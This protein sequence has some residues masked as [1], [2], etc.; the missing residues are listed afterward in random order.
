MKKFLA[1][2]LTLLMVLSLGTVAL[3]GHVYED[4]VTGG[5]CELD[6]ARGEHLQPGESYVFGPDGS[7]I[8]LTEVDGDVGNTTASDAVNVDGVEDAI[9]SL[10]IPVSPLHYLD[11]TPDDAVAPDKA[12]KVSASWDIGGA[13]VEGV[14]WD[15][16]KEFQYDGD[17][18]GAFV[19]KL[20]ENYTISELKRLEGTVTFTSKIDKN[21][22]LKAKI[23]LEVSNHKVIV[24]GYKKAADAE[25]DPIAASNNTLY[26]CSED[27]PGYVAFNGDGYLLSCTLKMLKNEQAFMYNDES[28]IDDV[29]EKYGDTDAR[30]DCYNF[31]GAPKFTNDAAFKLQADYAD[32]YKIY[33]WDGTK[34]TP[35][36]DYKW[37]S[38]NGVYTWTTKT[39]TAYVISDKELIAG[40]ET[41]D[42]ADKTTKNP[43]TGANDV[44]GVA[45]AL[46][47]VSLAAAAA[48][49]L[50]K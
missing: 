24:D 44:V 1:L 25:D 26:K 6:P 11:D 46:A 41:A 39:P 15:K 16:N 38:I 9:K 45:A 40:A 28:M 5:T 7:D 12:W 49:S 30:I 42:T 36:K 34:L 32:Q 37:D 3:A 47:V 4:E 43:D 17:Q 2:L 13:M 35:K 19:L 22:T 50:R 10:I 18:K 21:A 23:K 20:N 29:E 31:G 33:T 8:E 48:V 14:K 27:N